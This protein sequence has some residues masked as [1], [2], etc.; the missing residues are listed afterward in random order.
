MVRR[1]FYFAK[2][3]FSLLKTEKSQILKTAFNHK[4]FFYQTFLQFPFKNNYE[5]WLIY[6]K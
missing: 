2:S 4:F 5:I 1:K 6:Q 3:E